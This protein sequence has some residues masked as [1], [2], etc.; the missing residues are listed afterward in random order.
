MR[1]LRIQILLALL[2]AAL[3]GLAYT[4]FRASYY[5]GGATPRDLERLAGRR[6]Q[7]WPKYDEPGFARMAPPKEGEWLFRFPENGQTFEEYLAAKPNK[8]V[9]GRETIYF[10]PLGPLSPRAKGALAAVASFSRAFFQLETRVLEEEPIFPDTFVKARREDDQYDA[11]KICD[12]LEKE[13]PADAL[14]YAGIAD[15]DLF[16]G[17]LNFVFGVGSFHRRVGVYSFLRFGEDAAGRNEKIYRKRAFQLV[18]HELGHILTLAHCIFYM[19]EQ[20]GSLSLWES[21]H[22]PS[23]AC[24]VCLKKLEWNVG[25][26]RKERYADLA[27]FYR[28]EGLDDDAKFCAERSK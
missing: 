24:P 5:R 20:N 8:R 22:T 14:I 25:F 28:S 26:D 6:A 19:C 16:S 9:P 27:A 12:H 3:G 10:R 23:H 21:D 4:S 2:L 1:A 15:A 13:R 17:D 18:S 11:D 7:E